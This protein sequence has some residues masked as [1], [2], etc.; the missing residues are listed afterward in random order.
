MGLDFFVQN[1]GI[2]YSNHS[3]VLYLIVTDGSR[4]V[5]L[6]RF[7]FS[8]NS[9]CKKIHRFYGKIPGNQLSVHIPLFLRA[10]PCGTFLEIKKW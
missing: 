3:K 8:K 4:S 1:R 6:G 7:W 5:C 10:S 9:H 2:S